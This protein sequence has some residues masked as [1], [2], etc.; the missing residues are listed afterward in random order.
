MKTPPKPR[1]PTLRQQLADSQARV[2]ALT[3]EL[4]EAKQTV[5]KW[6]STNQEK[7]QQFTKLLGH[8]RSSYGTFDR[9]S[10]LAWAEIF[11]YL[12]CVTTRESNY[13]FKEEFSHRLEMLTSNLEAVQAVLRKD[14]P[15]TLTPL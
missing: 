10:T 13:G 5:E 6:E 11:Y 9:S 12:G 8:G 1:K 14:V 15:N 4:K 7:K 2:L 3:Q